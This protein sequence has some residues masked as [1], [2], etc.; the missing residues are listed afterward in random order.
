MK[1]TTELMED[2]FASARMNLVPVKD[3]AGEM[4]IPERIYNDWLVKGSKAGDDIFT[5]FADGVSI[6]EAT[7]A[8]EVQKDIVST[9][10]DPRGSSSATSKLHLAQARFPKRF[11]KR[12]ENTV[13]HTGGLTVTVVRPEK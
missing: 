13:E 12:Q 10:N 6:C 4:G 5:K 11:V 3:A 8:I 7:I 2:I 1:L 9:A